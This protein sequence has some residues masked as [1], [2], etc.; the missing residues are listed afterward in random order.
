MTSKTRHTDG[1]S[2][3]DSCPHRCPRTRRQFLADSARTAWVA[4]SGAA[5]IP[6]LA[7][8]ADA[9]KTK[10]RVVIVTHPEALKKGNRANPE[11]VAKM[12]EV[13]IKTVTGKQSSEE[14]WQDI[15]QP[16]QQATIKYNE[17]GGRLVCVHE[18]VRN[19]VADAL[20]KHGGLEAAKVRQWGNLGVKG[21]PARIVKV[22]LDPDRPP[23]KL[24]RLFTDFTD[25][26]INLGVLKTHVSKGVSIC[27]KNHFGS[28]ANPRDFHSWESGMVE[29]IVR[30]NSLPAIKD[31]TRLAIA[32]ALRPQWHFGP[33]YIPGWQWE[34]KGLLFSFD[35]V[36]ADAVG[37]KMLEDYRKAS[38]RLG[39]NWQLPHAHKLLAHAQEKGLGVADLNRI[40]IERIDMKA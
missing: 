25:S 24:R 38:R 1:H 32:D 33:I 31:H 35:S 13:G 5:A 20:V 34:F 11:V 36:A 8:A 19:A 28:I 23:A 12:L 7:G 3:A 17:L 10:S 39:R 16:G 26:L 29:R 37:T 27:L 2:H 6:S 22:S 21:E 40:E 14:A 9:A 4:G 30:L 15:A 18:N